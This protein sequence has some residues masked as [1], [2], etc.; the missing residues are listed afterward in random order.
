MRALTKEQ[1]VKKAIKD[2]QWVTS[3]KAKV[4]EYKRIYKANRIKTDPNFK[5]LNLLRSRLYHS[6]KASQWIKSDKREELLGADII[7]VKAR[8]ESLFTDG[9]N[10]NNMSEWHIDHILPIGKCESLE[11]MVNR[12]HY[13]NLQPLWAI[14]NLKKSCSLNTNIK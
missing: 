6:F 3:N 5:L 8:I 2:K 4:N 11:E 9:M 14:D 12:C 10:W 13:K 1:K 7:T